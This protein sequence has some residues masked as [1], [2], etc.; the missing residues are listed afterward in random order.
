MAP[1]RKRS[2]HSFVL[3]GFSHRERS[4]LSLKIATL[5]GVY[6]ETKVGGPRRYSNCLYI[7]AL[8]KLFV[9]VLN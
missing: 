9:T 7:F 4:E 8:N 2:H 6:N 1:D 3:T 5:G